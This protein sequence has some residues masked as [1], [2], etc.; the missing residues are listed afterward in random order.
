MVARVLFVI[1]AL[2]EAAIVGEVVRQVLEVADRAV[3]VDDGSTDQ[4]AAVSRSAGATVVRHDINLGQGA[5]LQTGI[6]VALRLGATHLVT[7]DADGQHRVEDAVRMVDRLMREH[8]DVVLG[9]RGPARRFG[10]PWVRHLM[11][12]GGLAFTRLTTGLDLT[13]THNGLRAFTGVAAA[14]LELT[15]NGMAHASE[16]ITRIA[17]L[18]LS[19]AEEPVQ[20]TYSEYALSKGQSN[21]AAL[22][23]VREMVASRLTGPPHRATV[24]RTRRQA[25]DRALNNASSA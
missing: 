13:D 24:L 17:A 4:T 21:L 22:E 12:R 2:N 18:Q 10:M 20:I 3:V 14:R 6:E 8:L 16:I 7:F 25:I 15:Q 9:T 1:P 23:I 5:A 19:W 11:I